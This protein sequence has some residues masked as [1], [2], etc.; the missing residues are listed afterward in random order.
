[1]KKILNAFDLVSIRFLFLVASIVI[2]HQTRLASA[3][4]AQWRVPYGPMWQCVLS[5]D[6]GRL[7]KDVSNGQLS[8]RNDMRIILSLELSR[9]TTCLMGRH[10]FCHR[11]KYT[12][13]ATADISR[14][15]LCPQ[16]SL[17]Y[18]F[19]RAILAALLGLYSP[20]WL[21][22]TCASPS[23]TLITGILQG[24]ANSFGHGFQDNVAHHHLG[25]TR[26][27]KPPWIAS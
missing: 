17:R 12:C 20:G 1:M 19:A 3:P 21:C 14:V 24:A 25:S 2:Q 23:T 16:R 15:S 4:L 9:L 26:A 10:V 7:M 5:G 13:P 6:F 22:G 8:G 11:Y 27:L 18:E